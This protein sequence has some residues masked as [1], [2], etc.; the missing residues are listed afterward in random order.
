MARIYALLGLTDW[1]Q[2]AGQQ[3]LE[4]TQRGN[5]PPF[6][7]GYAYEALARAEAVAGRGTETAVYL[8]Q[9]YQA[10]AQITDAQAREQLLTDLATIPHPAPPQ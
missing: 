8:Q 2:R 7:L 10:A 4:V 1:A 5:L 3:C 6:Y 9:A